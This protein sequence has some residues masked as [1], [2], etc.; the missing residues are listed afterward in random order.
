MAAHVKELQKLLRDIHEA[1]K[2]WKNNGNWKKFLKQLTGFGSDV[3][4]FDKFEKE[5]TS[6]LA[7][8]AA[9]L[10]IHLGGK[11]SADIQALFE[12]SKLSKEAVDEL[13]EQLNHVQCAVET[14][15]D[16]SAYQAEVE[17]LKAKMC[18]KYSD[19]S[20]SIE[21]AFDQTAVHARDI[22]QLFVS[23]KQTAA[24]AKELGSQLQV[25]RKDME[26][27]SLQ[28]HEKIN[29]LKTS[30]QHEMA[31]LKATVDSDVQTLL[32]ESTLSHK[33]VDDLREQLNHVQR[34]VETATDPSA[35]Q[36]EVEE[37]K[38]KMCEQYSMFPKVYSDVS[39]LVEKA[40]DK[41]GELKTSTRHEMETLKAT[42]YAHNQHEYDGIRRTVADL[43]RALDEKNDA[44]SEE[45]VE[46]LAKSFA[47]STEEMGEFKVATR[48][49]IFDMRELITT[50]S[51]RMTRLERERES[52]RGREKE[53]WREREERWGE[54]ERER[55]KVIA[56]K[57]EQ[58]EKARKEQ[59]EKARKEQEEKARKEQEEKARKEQA[60]EEEKQ[61]KS[62]AAAGTVCVGNSNSASNQSTGDG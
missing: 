56:R 55:E 40:V 52:E 12:E 20:A 34:V 22:Q 26:S 30:T 31:T 6:R 49:E 32:T 57:A 13:R 10:S 58:E 21:K 53:R 23:T 7:D 4:D 36:A 59:E 28:T 24:Q 25:V 17:E 42:M 39:V 15:T 5:M 48:Q 50:M 46:E 44:A 43:Q 11:F 1:V 29:E 2:Q 19:I 9:E 3:S 33:A 60:E 62:L 54:R 16:P 14:A 35:Y 61:R 27:M 38:A 47:I 18:D 41:I 51:D 8:L 37:L 45:Q